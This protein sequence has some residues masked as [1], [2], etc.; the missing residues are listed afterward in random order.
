ML[1]NLLYKFKNKRQD[2]QSER[3][4]YEM[5]F[6]R[7]YYAAYF[8][9]QD[10]ELAQDVAQETFLKAFRQLHTVKEADKLGAW[11]AAIASRTAI[12]Q[13]RKLKRWNDSA[14]EDIIIDHELSKRDFYVSEVESIIENEA[15]K[16]LLLQQLDELRPDHKQVLLLR[17]IH[18][19]TNAEIAEALGVNVGTVKTRLYR[20]RLKFR[21]VLEQRPDVKELIANAR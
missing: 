6:E 14:T 17:Y 11:L 12:D 9:I 19:M 15:L 2:Q 10:R 5:F 16:K 3:L 13:L 1:K 21:E 8:I 18:D 7:V 20:A 4:I